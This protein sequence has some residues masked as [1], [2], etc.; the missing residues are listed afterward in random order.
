MSG[1]CFA[2]GVV[3]D[4]QLPCPVHT[5]VHKPEKVANKPDPVV[6]NKPEVVANTVSRRGKYAD[7]EKRKAYQREL[8]R[9]R[10]S[11]AA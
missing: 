6:A 4:W 1:K 11:D 3:H 5:V 8:M 10:R 7:A 2:C 9:K